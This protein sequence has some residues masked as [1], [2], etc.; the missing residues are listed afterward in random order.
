MY[1]PP[2]PADVLELM[3]SSSQVFLR[4]ANKQ[5]DNSIANLEDVIIDD[6]G[7]MASSTVQSFIQTTDKANTTFS[8]SSPSFN[9]NPADS[10]S[11]IAADLQELPAIDSCNDLVLNI[12]R[13]PSSN[14]SQQDGHIFRIWWTEQ[15]HAIL[16]LYL[17]LFFI[18]FQFQKYKFTCTLSNEKSPM[19]LVGYARL[20]LCASHRRAKSAHGWMTLLR[21]TKNRRPRSVNNARLEIKERMMKQLLRR[22]SMQWIDLQALLQNVA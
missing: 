2:P 1:V 12:D 11:Q 6:T 21:E 17:S 13:P 18:L 10:S 3:S 4:F 19:T 5:R 20:N 9:Q 22:G 7:S 16:S 14:S 15:P 8:R